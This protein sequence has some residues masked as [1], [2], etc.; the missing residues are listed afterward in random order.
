MQL[1]LV[2]SISIPI[3]N[4]IKLDL[5]QIINIQQQ[6]SYKTLDRLYSH[7]NTQQKKHE[8]ISSHCSWG[9]GSAIVSLSWS[10]RFGGEHIICHRSMSHKQLKMSRLNVSSV[11]VVSQ[12][13]PRAVAKVI[14]SFNGVLAA[15]SDEVGDFDDY[16]DEEFDVSNEGNEDMMLMK[17]GDSS[18]FMQ[19][20]KESDDKKKKTNKV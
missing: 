2:V 5:R 20:S 18:N 16:E 6:H 14:E 1:L 15:L 4:L 7:A 13:S 17:G 12:E 3:Y 11:T 10:S 8:T 9:F 19:M